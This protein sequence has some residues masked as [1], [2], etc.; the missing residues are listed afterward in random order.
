[1]RWKCELPHERRFPLYLSFSEVCRALLCRMKIDQNNSGYNNYYRLPKKYVP[2]V[3]LF[4]DDFR[5][6]SETIEKAGLNRTHQ[7]TCDTGH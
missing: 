4:T 7:E 6:Y 1:M 5:L 3:Y 2:R